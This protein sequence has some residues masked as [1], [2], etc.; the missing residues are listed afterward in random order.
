M[1][2]D[3][4]SIDIYTVTKDNKIKLHIM[5]TGKFND[6]NEQQQILLKKVNNYIEF[7]KNEDY[8]EEYPDLSPIDKIIVFSYNRKPT[9]LLNELLKDIEKKVKNENINFELDKRFLI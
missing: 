1:I 3:E 8:K 5:A 9:I 6:T 2:Y 4:N 7:F